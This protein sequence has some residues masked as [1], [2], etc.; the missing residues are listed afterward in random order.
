MASTSLSLGRASIDN[1]PPKHPSNFILFAPP[2]VFLFYSL[3]G[4]NG[5]ILGSQGWRPL[6]ERFWID[7]RKTVG[8]KRNSINGND[9]CPSSRT[10]SRS[11]IG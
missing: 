4:K 11:M 2:N 6:S 8:K 9:H 10:A 7:H 3:F 5:E 1:R